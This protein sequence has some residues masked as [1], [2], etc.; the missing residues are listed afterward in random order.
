MAPNSHWQNDRTARSAAN[1]DPDDHIN[2]DF[3]GTPASTG[4]SSISVV[5]ASKRLWRSSDLGMHNRMIGMRRNESQLGCDR[6]AIRRLEHFL[7]GLTC[8]GARL[9]GPEPVQPSR[10][11]PARRFPMTTAASSAA[12]AAIQPAPTAPLPAGP[13]GRYSGNSRAVACRPAAV[14]HDS[15]V[16]LAC[17]PRPGTSAL[18]S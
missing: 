4:G 7:D 5:L 8:C 10:S 18:R 9:P 11:S 3:A 6:A 1:P 13:C 12:L 14:A 2:D 16:R 15:S 17:G